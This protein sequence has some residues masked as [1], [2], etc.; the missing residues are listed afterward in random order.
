MK[1]T[2]EQQR[3]HKGLLARA[4][5]L[6][7][8]KKTKKKKEKKDGRDTMRRR[9]REYINSLTWEKRKKQY[10]RKYGKFCAICGSI[11]NINLH[12][13][14]YAMVGKEPDNH[15]VPLCE[16]HH[17]EYHKKYPSPSK[18]TTQL[19]IRENKIWNE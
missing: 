14:S 4:D 2:Y 19:F 16:T 9:H 13:K 15:L 17:K 11:N 18:R 3:K 6:L 7:S 5:F 1:Y 10:Y 12:H 8:G